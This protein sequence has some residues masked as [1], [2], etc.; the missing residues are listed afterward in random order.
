MLSELGADSQRMLIVV[1][2]MDKVEADPD[3]CLELRR[4]FEDAC[5]ISA[6]TGEGIEELQ[7]RMTEMLLDRVCRLELRIPQAR[8]DLVSLI[9]RSGKILTQ[10]YDGNDILISATVPKRLEAKFAEFATANA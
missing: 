7:N 3:R 1:N 8:M 9:H 10:D 5:F 6:Q 2:K 4:H